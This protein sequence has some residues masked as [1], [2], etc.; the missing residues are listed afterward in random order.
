MKQPYPQSKKTMA[1]QA[2]RH[3]LYEASVQDTEP[4]L[5]FVSQTF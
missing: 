3:R 5:E 2:D 4:E 1:E